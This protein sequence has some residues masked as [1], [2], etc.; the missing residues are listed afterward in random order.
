MPARITNPRIRIMTIVTASPVGKRRC[1][2]YLVAGTHNIEIKIAT[3][4]GTKMTLAAC[5]ANITAIKAIIE[6]LIVNEERDC[7]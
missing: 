2:R 4:R 6:A 5:M 3:S 7:F 1:S